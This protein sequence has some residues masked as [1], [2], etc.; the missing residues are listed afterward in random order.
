MMTDRAKARTLAPGTDCA[1][2][3]RSRSSGT[4]ARTRVLD[5][6]P[7]R[8]AT[9]EPHGKFNR[10]RAAGCPLAN[11]SPAITASGGYTRASGTVVHAKRPC[12]FDKNLKAASVR[13]A[14]AQGM[15]RPSK[16]PRSSASMPRSHCLRSRS[17]TRSA[18]RQRRRLDPPVQ[19]RD[20]DHG[21]LVGY[22]REGRNRQVGRSDRRAAH[23]VISAGSAVGNISLAPRLERVVIGLGEHLVGRGGQE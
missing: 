22:G 21:N 9:I 5:P 13:D 16:S 11:R 2:A 20:A 12:C 8:S 10:S 7:L 17:Q 1:R 6:Q 4:T 3:T 19:A 15:S 14:V 23:R 18:R